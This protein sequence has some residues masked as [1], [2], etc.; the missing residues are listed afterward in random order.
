MVHAL[1]E[2]STAVITGASSGIG[3]AVALR[4]AKRQL[5]NLVLV[6]RDERRLNTV[7]RKCLE[8]GA[9][10][11]IAIATDLRDREQV[12]RIKDAA[13]TAGHVELLVNNAGAGIFKPTPDFTDNDWDTIINLNLRAVFTLTRGLVDH[14]LRSNIRGTVI[15]ISSDCDKVGFAEAAV[16]CA[17]KGGLLMMSSA[18]QAELQPKGI[19]VCVISPGRVDTC[20]NSKQPGMRPGALEADHVAEVVEFAAF[21]SRGIELQ[22]IRIESMA[23]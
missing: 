12:E 13:I 9:G 23:R 8:L 10:N 11:A 20:F 18:L 22:E 6:A 7:A 1:Y 5:P 14:M 19:R 21:C 16:Y 2:D 3:A 15:N 4:L 17:S